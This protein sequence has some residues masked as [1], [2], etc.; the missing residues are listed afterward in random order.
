[1]DMGWSLFVVT[2]VVG[3]IGVVIGG[4]TSDSIVKKYGIRS[5][6]AVLA[7]SQVCKEHGNIKKHKFMISAAWVFMQ[8]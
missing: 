6:V 4:I 1:M 5:R 2:F 8:I 3:S 7:I